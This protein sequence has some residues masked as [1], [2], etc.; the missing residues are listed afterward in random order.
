MC[1]SIGGRQHEECAGRQEALK[2]DIEH[3]S[4]I[5]ETSNELIQQHRTT[6]EKCKSRADKLQQQKKALEKCVPAIISSDQNSPFDFSLHSFVDPSL[7]NV[8]LPTL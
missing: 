5:L 1:V 3:K 2:R 4:A 7:R 8:I 6:A